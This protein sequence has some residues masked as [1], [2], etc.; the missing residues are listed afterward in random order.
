M[1]IKNVEPSI[2]YDQV[3]KK[4]DGV[5]VFI[6]QILFLLVMAYLAPK[7][8]SVYIILFFFSVC[9]FLG[10]IIGTIVGMLIMSR[11]KKN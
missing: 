7:H 5:G 2:F 1:L 11:D 10:R 6:F 9:S 3:V 8:I 4:L